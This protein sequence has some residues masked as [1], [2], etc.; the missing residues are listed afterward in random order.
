LPGS[1]S[2]KRK[3]INDLNPPAGGKG[4]VPQVPVLKPREVIRVFKKFGL[5]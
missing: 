2:R 5:I 3:T 1:Q 4:I